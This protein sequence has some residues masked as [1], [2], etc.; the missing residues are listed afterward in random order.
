MPASSEKR[1]EGC[2]NAEALDEDQGRGCGYG[3]GN[4]RRAH[5]TERRR[6]ELAGQRRN[7]DRDRKASRVDEYPEEN[8]GAEYRDR[9]AQLCPR[10]AHLRLARCPG[11][12]DRQSEQREEPLT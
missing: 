8:D 1:P 3:D 7:C 6:S 4:R 11:D 10:K 12:E 5:E 2:A 9:A